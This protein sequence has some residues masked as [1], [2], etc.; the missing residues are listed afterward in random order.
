MKHL[1]LTALIGVAF[2]SI[3]QVQGGALVGADA[4]SKNITL[5]R[6]KEFLM[7][8]VLGVGSDVV[9]FEAFPLSAATSGDLTSLVYTCESK[10]KSGLVLAFYG[11]TLNGTSIST[12]AYA[13]KDLP[14]E[15]AVEVMAQLTRILETSISYLRADGDN[16]NIYF[17]YDDLTFL[18][19]APPLNEPQIRVFWNGFDCQWESGSFRRTRDR[20]NKKI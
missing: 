2:P 19:Y 1:L 12:Q 20:M 9:R 11:Y 18:V 13:F 16:N 5:Y 4:Y 3:A 7:K 10:H 14:K 6:A 15:K 17:K 8:E